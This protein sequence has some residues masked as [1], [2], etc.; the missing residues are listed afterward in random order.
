MRKVVVRNFLGQ[1][2][3]RMG[4]FFSRS[5]LIFFEIDVVS[6]IMAGENKMTTVM[7]IITVYLFFSQIS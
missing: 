5:S 2:H 1:I 3:I 4:I 6:I 7:I